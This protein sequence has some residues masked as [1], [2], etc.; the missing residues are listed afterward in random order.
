MIGVYVFLLSASLILL[1]LAQTIT[2]EIVLENGFIISY[3][4]L[5]LKFSIFPFK[6][7]FS[8]FRKKKRKKNLKNTKRLRL[9]REIIKKSDIKILDVSIPLDK[10]LPDVEILQKQNLTN[11]LSFIVS[12]LRLNARSVTFQDSKYENNAGTA[13]RI[14][15]KTLLVD[16]IYSILFCYFKDFKRKI[17][18]G[19]FKVVR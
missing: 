5:F 13:I 3:D 4:F 19:R 15:F 11:I 7:V 1:T 8:H 16:I 12:F 2:T 6:N 17:S 18:K 9:F 14:Q 10:N